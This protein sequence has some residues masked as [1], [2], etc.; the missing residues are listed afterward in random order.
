M[1]TFERRGEPLL[2]GRRFATRVL[3][4]LG[5]AAMIDGVAIIL[6]A[7]G[8]HFLQGLTWLEGALQASLMITGNGPIYPPQTEA[9]KIFALFDAWL[10]VI[11]FVTVTGVLLAPLLH[12]VLHSFNLE[13]PAAS[14][15]ENSGVSGRTEA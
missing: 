8:F 4:F 12:R 3:G 5:L 7:L 14:P 10:G 2:S 15:T 6:G 11:V 9:A 1:L 13:V